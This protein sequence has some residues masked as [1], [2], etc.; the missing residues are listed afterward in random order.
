MLAESEG[1]N[2]MLA[3]K[4]RL[5]EES[6]ARALRNKTSL[7]ALH[8]SHRSVL[9]AHA[10]Q[11]AEHEQVSLQALESKER[12]EMEYSSLRRGMQTMADGF[13]ADLDWVKGDMRR[14]E[15]SH[16]RDLVDARLK[17]ASRMSCLVLLVLSVADQSIQWSRCIRRE[18]SRTPTSQQCLGWYTLRSRMSTSL[19]PGVTREW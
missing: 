16:Q 9:S 8:Q 4:D 12:T 1:L 5:Q 11:L 2:K 19:F 18:R 7:A 3:R 10:L 6:V 14:L 17:H 13:K 15:S